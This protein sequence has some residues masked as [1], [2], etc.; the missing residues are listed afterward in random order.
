MDNVQNCGHY[1]FLRYVERYSVT[2][3]LDSFF[4]HEDGGFSNGP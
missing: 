1:I 2:F 4:N 3:L